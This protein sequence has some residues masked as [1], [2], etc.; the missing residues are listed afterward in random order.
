MVPSPGSLETP[1]AP[2]GPRTMP[3]AAESPRPR[4]RNLVVKKARRSGSGSRVHAGPGVGHIHPDVVAGR[5]E[6]LGAGPSRRSVKPRCGPGP[7]GCPAVSPIASPP[8]MTRFITSCWSWVRS[9]SIRRQ[10]SGTSMTRVTLFE[11]E[12]RIRVL[13][14]PHEPTEIDRLDYEPPLSRIGQQL[15][16]QIGGRSLAAR[17]PPAGPRLAPAVR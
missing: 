5:W 8:L 2:R 1:M 4:P 3:S 14:S 6:A 10:L 7:S 13:T 11:M 17:R 16:G 15:T 12:V 9:A